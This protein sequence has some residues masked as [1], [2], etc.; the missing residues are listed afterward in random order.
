[1]FKKT[2]Q[3][4]SDPGREILLKNDLRSQRHQHH[5]PA[6]KTLNERADKQPEGISTSIKRRE[7]ILLKKSI[8][9]YF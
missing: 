7:E 1:M 2:I 4:F 5:G 9:F 8:R 6:R 3:M